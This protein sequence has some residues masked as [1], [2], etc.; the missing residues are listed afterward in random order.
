MVRSSGHGKLA[1]RKCW[2]YTWNGG[3]KKKMEKGE[4]GDKYGLKLVNLGTE[5]LSEGIQAPLR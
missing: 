3:W 1:T 2:V 4:F 5:S